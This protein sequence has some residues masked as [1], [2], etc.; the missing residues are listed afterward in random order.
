MSTHCHEVITDVRGEYPDF[1]G[2]L[3]RNLA[4][5]DRQNKG[6]VRAVRNANQTGK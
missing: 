2:T 3:H 5:A 1:L 6:P 4:L